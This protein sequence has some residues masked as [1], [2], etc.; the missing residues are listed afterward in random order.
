VA[1]EALYSQ[2]RQIIGPDCARYFPML[3][4]F[5]LFIFVS[6][7]LGLIPGFAPPTDN[8]NTT[9]ACGIFVFIYYNYHGIRT[10]GLGH[11]AH[12]ANPVGEPWGWL[13]APLMFP[14]EL[15]SHCA[16]PFSLGVRL[17]ANMV[18]DHAV[19]LGFLGLVPILVP[20]PFM[21]LGL[22]VSLIQT[23]VFVLL[24][25][26]YI[27]MATAD[28]HHGADEGAA[29]HGFGDG[30]LLVPMSGRSATCHLRL[31]EV[32]KMQRLKTMSLALSAFVGTF[33][34]Q[35]LA[36]AQ[37][38]AAEAH[39]PSR[40]GPVAVAVA[41]GIGLSVL[42][43]AFGQ[44]RAAAAALEGIARNPGAADKVFVPMILGLA[45]IESLVLFA[46]VLMFLLL[47]KI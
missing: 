18:G 33:L 6:N 29:A 9:F 2:S 35:N 14:I 15:V 7:V 1:L 40:M 36:L 16:R 13:L 12:M 25:M 34:L 17:A 44:S 21:V 41:L 47:Q 11:I 26:I 37:E 4:T 27:G 32:N 30:P 31:R 24:S 45:F 5:T 38:V 22:M 23:L 20:L 42:G 3:A 8:W 28:A 46:W 10:H 19:L 43:A 39:G